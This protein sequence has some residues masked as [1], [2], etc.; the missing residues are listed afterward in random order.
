MTSPGRF[1]RT[2]FVLWTAIA[3]LAGFAIAARFVPAHLL[4]LAVVAAL[5]AT[6]PRTPQPEEE[7]SS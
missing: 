5:I 7:P 6:R 4:L 3:L 1:F 2:N